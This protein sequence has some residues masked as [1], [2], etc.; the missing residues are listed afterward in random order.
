MQ[1]IFFSYLPTNQTK[2]YRVGV[3]QTNN[4]LRM[5]PYKLVVGTLDSRTTLLRRFYCR[6]IQGLCLYVEILCL[7]LW[8]YGLFEP[9]HEKIC[10]CHMRT[11]NTLIRL[12]ISLICSFLNIYSSKK[13]HYFASNVYSSAT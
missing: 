8:S 6:S 11:T 13:K 3:Q 2:N 5:A 10:F 9:H 7:S 4:F 1:F 12:Y